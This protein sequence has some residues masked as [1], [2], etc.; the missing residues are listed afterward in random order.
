MHADQESRFGKLLHVAHGGLSR[1]VVSRRAAR[2]L[3]WYLTGRS[4]TWP[5]LRDQ[6]RRLWQRRGYNLGQALAHL[7]DS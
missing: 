2:P 7:H 6:D 3:R 5:R 4:V 1:R